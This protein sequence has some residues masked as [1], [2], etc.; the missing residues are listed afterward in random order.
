[1][2][3]TTQE[4]PLLQ[5]IQSLQAGG[6]TPLAEALVVANEY[7]R[8]ASSPSSRNQ[9]IVLLADGADDQA[10]ATLVS[11]RQ[12]GMNYRHETIG[13][14]V[15]DTD[16]AAQQL[17]QVAQ[18]SGGGY[19][20]AKEPEDLARAFE[21]AMAATQLLDMMGTFGTKKTTTKQ[22]EPDTTSKPKKPMQSILD[23][24]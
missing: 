15:A 14:G 5:C 17:K 13:L 2:N 12:K 24:F 11:L 20:Q 4:E 19:H 1:V 23:T 16:A 22:R 6:G 9:M 7:M 3:F 10:A 21:D 18:S 8:D